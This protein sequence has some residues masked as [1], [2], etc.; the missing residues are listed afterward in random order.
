MVLGAW[1][2]SPVDGS[3]FVSVTISQF[4]LAAWPSAVIEFNGGPVNLVL[5]FAG[6]QITPFTVFRDDDLGIRLAKPLG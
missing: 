4:R 6:V 2:W 1:R 5:T 3:G